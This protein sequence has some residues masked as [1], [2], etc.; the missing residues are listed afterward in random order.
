MFPQLV[1]GVG[2]ERAE[3]HSLRAR[4]ALQRVDGRLTAARVRLYLL[5]KAT[6][7]E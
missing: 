5:V 6:T 1:E 4:E 3:S 2:E 7:R